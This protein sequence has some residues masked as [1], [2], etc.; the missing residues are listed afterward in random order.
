MTDTHEPFQHDPDRALHQAVTELG[1]IHACLVDP[2]IPDG[3][4]TG[5]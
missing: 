1:S 2:V 4:E 3:T 5:D